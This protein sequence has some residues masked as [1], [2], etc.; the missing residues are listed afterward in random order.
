VKKKKKQTKEETTTT[1]ETGSTDEGGEEEEETPRKK[2]K[3][4]EAAYSNT[5]GHRRVLTSKK[6]NRKNRGGLKEKGV[7]IHPPTEVKTK[8]RKAATT[9]TA[10]KTGSGKKRKTT[11]A[12]DRV[13]KERVID[14]ADIVTEEALGRGVWRVHLQDR[15]N[16]I[17][18]NKNS[19]QVNK[20]GE[21][22]KKHR[23]HPG[24]VA[25]REIRRYQKTTDNLLAKAPFQRLIREI[26]QDHKQLPD[27]R[28]QST[29]ILALQEAAETFIVEQ[30]ENT[31]LCAIH[32]KR[33]T[34]MPKDMQ[35]AG[36]IYRRGSGRRHQAS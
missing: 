12:V 20:K 25:L 9:A 6:S 13:K 34:I 28:F 15:K 17:H 7:V 16:P 32:A 30:M 1:E 27:L 29:A 11:A 10:T 22:L 14:K 4:E 33:V 5:R 2:T 23:Y 19:I 35:L 21:A 36:E 8:K 24:T 18:I 3:E 26:A 31:N